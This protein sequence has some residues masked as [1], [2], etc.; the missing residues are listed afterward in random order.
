MGGEG[1]PDIEDRAQEEGCFPCWVRS[2]TRRRQMVRLLNERKVLLDRP[3]VGIEIR[4]NDLKVRHAYVSRMTPQA[5]YKGKPHLKAPFGAPVHNER[6]RQVDPQRI[7]G[8]VDVFLFLL[9]IQKLFQFL[10]ARSVIRIEVQT[11]LNNALSRICKRR[12]AW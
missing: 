6:F 11:L 1:V 5:A 7:L 10:K 2:R 3:N 4:K 8:L 12:G 9:L